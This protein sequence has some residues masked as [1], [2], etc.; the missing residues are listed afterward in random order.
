MFFNEGGETEEVGPSK[1]IQNFEDL[2]RVRLADEGFIVI[3]DAN[4]PAIIHKVNAKCI[5]TDK[6]NSK[7]SINDRKQGS[8]YWADSVATA[9]R[10]FGAKRCKVCKPELRLV[11]PSTLDG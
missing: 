2:R 7:V 3:T 1:E 5:T 10:E 11:P 9:A 4:R 8:Y 6:F